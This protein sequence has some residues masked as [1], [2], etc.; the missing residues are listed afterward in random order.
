M[1]QLTMSL[2][3]EKRKTPT[4]RLRYATIEDIQKIDVNDIYF[5]KNLQS[6]LF[7]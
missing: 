4:K 1:N 2:L 3:V 6:V 5:E 7:E